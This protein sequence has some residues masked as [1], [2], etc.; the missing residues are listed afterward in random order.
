MPFGYGKKGTVCL[1]TVCSHVVNNQTLAA[2]FV[3]YPCLSLL[4]PNT[5]KFMTS[6]YTN[7]V[8]FLNLRLIY[9]FLARTSSPHY[10]A[11]YSP[12]YEYMDAAWQI[13]S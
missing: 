1:Y 4:T 7:T 12:D 2:Q 10:C 6:K 3:L 5:E 13:T 8:C 11:N 9:K